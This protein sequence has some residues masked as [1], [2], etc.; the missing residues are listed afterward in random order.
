[1]KVRFPGA[2]RSCTR[3]AQA[4]VGGETLDALAIVLALSGG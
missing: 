3:V 1:M 4:V 2:L